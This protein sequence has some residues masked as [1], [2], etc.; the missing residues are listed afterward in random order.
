MSRMTCMIAS[1][2]SSSL[3]W[4]L[5]LMKIGS[6][7]LSPQVAFPNPGRAEPVRDACRRCFRLELLEG[8]LDGL[9]RDQGERR[10]LLFVDVALRRGLSAPLLPVSRTEAR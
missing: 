8:A 9:V 6:L 1:A 10:I 2:P 7:T 5:A 3:P 4:M